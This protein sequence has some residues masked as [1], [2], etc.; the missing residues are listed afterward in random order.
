MSSPTPLLS[1]TNPSPPLNP[2]LIF[3]HEDYYCRQL[4][5]N[6]VLWENSMHDPTLAIADDICEQNL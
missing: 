3:R 5:A 2:K 6:L 1:A 4:M